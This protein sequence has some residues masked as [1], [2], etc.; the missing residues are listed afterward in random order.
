MMADEL[1]TRRRIANLIVRDAL[2]PA[3]KTGG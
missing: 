1:A 3:G 2:A